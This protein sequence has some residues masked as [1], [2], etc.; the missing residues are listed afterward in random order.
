MNTH[1]ISWNPYYIRQQNARL[2]KKLI[3]KYE[4]IINNNTDFS[5]CPQSSRM[6]IINLVLIIV[7]LE[8]LMLWEIPEKYSLILNNELIMLQLE[9]LKS[10]DYLILGINTK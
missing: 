9:D 1:S 7:S 6:S 3:D 2:L 5:T 4:L 10:Q 8:L